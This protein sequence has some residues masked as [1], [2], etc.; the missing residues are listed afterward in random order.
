M[1]LSGSFFSPFFLMFLFINKFGFSYL[2]I[3][4]YEKQG[5][6]LSHMLLDLLLDLKKK[7]NLEYVN[8]SELV[9]IQTMMGL[10]EF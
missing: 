1:V 4:C 6:V 10:R 3:W 7:A 2:F 5:E 9:S 8:E